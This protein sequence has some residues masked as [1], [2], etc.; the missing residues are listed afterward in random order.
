MV[1]LVVLVSHQILMDLP[2][3]EQVVAVL[4]DQMLEVVVLAVLVVVALEL[5]IVELVDLDLATLEAV[6]V[7]LDQE[8]EHLVLVDQV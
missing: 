3:L 2:Q 7:E 8:V 5:V 1:V 4:L 6:V